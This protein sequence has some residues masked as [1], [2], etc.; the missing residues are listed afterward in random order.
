MADKVTLTH[1]PRSAPL[2]LQMAAN[3]ADTRPSAPPKMASGDAVAY[4][5]GKPLSERAM[6]L[7]AHKDSI[8]QGISSAKAALATLDGIEKLLGQMKDIA[9]NAQSATDEER[10]ALQG[11]FNTLARQ[12]ADLSDQAA[13]Q[14]A[15]LADPD[16]AAPENAGAGLAAIAWADDAS[17]DAL[18]HAVNGALADVQSNAK[19]LDSKV[20]QL[21]TRLNSAVTALSEGTEKLPLA[22][23]NA[24]GANLLALQTRQQLGI[25]SLSFA[26]AQEQSVLNLF[27]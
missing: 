23:L 11:A 17:A 6:D 18:T 10:V 20:M 8:G 27:R 26:G 16:G 25:Q 14:G 19:A 22:E 7:N 21:Q 9:Q 2:P 12:V 15:T 3:R 13:R 1:T 24:E 4:V 5:Q